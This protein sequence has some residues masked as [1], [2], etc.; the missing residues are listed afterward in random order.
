M[1]G[2]IRIAIEMRTIVTLL[3]SWTKWALLLGHGPRLMLA[4]KTGNENASSS[5]VSPNRRGEQ[6]TKWLI[7][8]G[9]SAS[10]VKHRIGHTVTVL[11][12]TRQN[13]R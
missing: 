6:R 1:A 10:A 11:R 13:L 4:W 2:I 9:E 8:G 5:Q 7:S 3:A 12:V